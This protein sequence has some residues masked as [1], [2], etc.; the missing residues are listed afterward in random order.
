MAK[1]RN[2]YIWKS[3]TDDGR[4]R[5][6]RAQRVAGKWTIRSRFTDEEDW[7]DHVRPSLEDLVDLE[8]VLFNKYQRKHTS[9]EFVV[10]VRKM[11]EE[12]RPTDAPPSDTAP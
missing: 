10:D 1:P 4:K 9:W 7:T 2:L 11:I 8:E 6:V 12:R 5:E 3:R